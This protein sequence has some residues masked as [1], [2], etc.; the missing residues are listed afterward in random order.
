[1]H[2]DESGQSERRLALVLGDGGAYG[3]VQAAYIQA[4]YEAGFRPSM[5]VGTSVGA[6]N[7][8]WVAMYPDEPEALVQIWHDLPL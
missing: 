8:A 5:V 6:L 7:G 2:R 1:M 4:A 3:V